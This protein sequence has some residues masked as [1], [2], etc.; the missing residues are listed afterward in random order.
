MLDAIHRAG[1]SGKIVDAPDNRDQVNKL[2]ID[3][4]QL[5]SP[6][7]ETF[8]RAAKEKRLVLIDLHGPG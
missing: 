5:P 2:L 1:F 8:G 4:E 7:R 6:L 3:L